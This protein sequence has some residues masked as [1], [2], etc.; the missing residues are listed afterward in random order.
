[1]DSFLESVLGDRGCSADGSTSRNPV[2]QIIDRVFESNLGFLGFDG[3][4]VSNEQSAYF[5]NN[6]SGTDAQVVTDRLNKKANCCIM[7]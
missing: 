3:G 5:V 7:K 2:S 4:T 6:S 1:M